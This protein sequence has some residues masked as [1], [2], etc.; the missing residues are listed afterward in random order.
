MADRKVYSKSST[1]RSDFVYVNLLPDVKRARQFNVNILLIVFFTVLL[2]GVIIFIPYRNRTEQLSSLNGDNSDLSYALILANE[3]LRGYEINLN[4]IHFYN[5]LTEVENLTVDVNSYISEVQDK[6]DTI[7]E[8]PLV[9]GEVASFNYDLENN[10][11]EVVVRFSS[12]STFT[13]LNNRFNDLDWVIRSTNTEPIQS[14]VL[15]LYESTYSLEVDYNA[16]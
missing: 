4:T 15:V 8:S 13:T 7:L 5:R 11:L 10:T 1:S 6:I 9:N 2:T 16:E 14:G 3:E 12:I